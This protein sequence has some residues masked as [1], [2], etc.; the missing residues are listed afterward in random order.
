LFVRD[1][2][3]RRT[4]RV[5]PPG[6][7]PNGHTWGG[8][9]SS[10]GRYLTFVSAAG[11]FVAGDTNGTWDAFMLDRQSGMFERVSVDSAGAQGNDGTHWAN[12]SDDGRYVAFNSF[13]S[14]LVPGDSNGFVDVFVRDRL[15]GQTRRVSVAPDKS[16]ATRESNLVAMSLDGRFVVFDSAAPNLVPGDTNRTFDA[17]LWDA[18]T[19]SVER[20]SVGLGGQQANNASQPQAVSADGRYVLISSWATNLVPDDTIDFAHLYVHDRVTGDNVRASVTSGLAQANESAFNGTMTPDGRFVAF[21]TAATNLSRLDKNDTFDAYMHEMGGTTSVYAFTVKPQAL[22]FGEQPVGSATTLSL[23]LRNKGTTDL[24]VQGISLRGVDRAQFQLAH[25]CG[26]TVAAGAGCAIQV[27]FAPTSA[28]A[29]TAKVRV[30]AGD[31]A[32]RTV[33]LSGSGV[34]AAMQ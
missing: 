15:L 23:W 28:G 16:D 8:Q 2:L 14:N 12:L 33:G 9:L 21:T 18:L 4:E 7:Q 27:T 24:P 25:R 19:D 20:V 6:V 5:A 11:N 26:K 31:G 13:A 17:F 1:R 22:A 30:E 32:L 3:L 34:A 29:K 10:D